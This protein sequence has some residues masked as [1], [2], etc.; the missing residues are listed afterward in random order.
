MTSYE[1]RAQDTRLLENGPNDK[2]RESLAKSDVSA[3]DAI[4]SDSDA[5][6]WFNPKEAD[7]YYKYDKL[8]YAQHGR[9][10]GADYS[11][12]QNE[13]DTKRDIEILAGQMDVTEYQQ[14]RCQHIISRDIDDLSEIGTWDRRV[15]IFALLTLIVN[16]EQRHIQQEDRYGDL[17]D[18]I[19]TSRSAIHEARERLREYI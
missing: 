3:P 17:I 5:A 14:N 13:S 8:T 12:R 19:G 2:R 7:D 4:D 11:E 18:D 1:K 9:H 10:K 15:V 6:T 16:K